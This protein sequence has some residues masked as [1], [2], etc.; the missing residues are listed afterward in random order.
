MSF[1]LAHDLYSYL[2]LPR[3]LYNQFMHGNSYPLLPLHPFLLVPF[4]LSQMHLLAGDRQV[5]IS[6]FVCSIGK[7]LPRASRC[8]LFLLSHPH[9]I[10]LVHNMYTFMYID[11]YV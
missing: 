6:M 2:S 5:F 10:C 7:A 9:C 4:S 1:S 8:F 11:A 3:S